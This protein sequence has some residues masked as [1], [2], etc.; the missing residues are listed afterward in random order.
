MLFGDNVEDA[1]GKWQFFLLIVCASLS[2]DL[3][4]ILSDPSSTIPCIG[5]SGGISG[6][7]AFYALK[8]PKVKLGFLLRIYFIFRW[9]RVPSVV[10][11]LLWIVLQFIGVAAQLRGF[12]NVSALAHLGGAGVGLV[13]WLLSQTSKRHDDEYFRG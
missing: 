13:F 1:L 2:G 11:F 4:H 6:V 7:M 5:A 12:S 8:F 3:I 10:I 9:I